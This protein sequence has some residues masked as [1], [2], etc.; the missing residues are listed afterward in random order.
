M[1]KS[2]KEA[3]AIMKKGEEDLERHKGQ[4]AELVKLAEEKDVA[5][6]KKLDAAQRARLTF[7]LTVNSPPS[8]PPPPPQSISQVQGNLPPITTIKR[9][10]VFDHV[11]APPSPHTRLRARGSRV[12]GSTFSC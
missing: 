4:V 5:L 3:E 7:D 9:P 2:R 12:C 10:D 1:K 8:S 6:K 11:A